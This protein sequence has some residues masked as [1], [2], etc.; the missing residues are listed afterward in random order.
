MNVIKTIIMI[1]KNSIDD[2]IN[3][4]FMIIMTK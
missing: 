1:L 3:K 4:K 2:N